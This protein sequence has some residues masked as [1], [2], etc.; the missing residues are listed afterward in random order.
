M[1]TVVL[2]LRMLLAAIFVTAAVG[3]LRDLPGSRRAVQDFGVPERAARA[4]AL[5]LPLAELAVAI[6]LIPQPSARWGALGAV[7]LLALF[8]AGIA[9]ALSRGEQP[10][11]HCF[12]QI[13]SAPAGRGTLVRNGVLA[14]LAVV[15][16]MYGNGPAIDDWISARGAAELAAV[17]LGICAIVAAAYAWTLRTENKTLSADLRIARKAGAIGGRFGLPVG[18][19][20]PSFVLEDMRREPVTLA[21]LRERG[22]PVLLLFVSPGCGPC[23]TMVPRV[24]QWQETLSERLTVAVVS[25]GTPEQNA[26][27]AEGGLEDVLLQDELEVAAAFHVQG[28]PTAVVVSR[29][30]RIASNL[31][32]M[33]QAIEPLVRLA[34]RQGVDV[35][36]VEGSVS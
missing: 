21:N 15:I 26:A 22:R 10:D 30:G 16:V 5:M 31:G 17:A 1:G 19:E 18:T 12:G 35:A 23:G 14:A 8:I 6:A 4:V 32:V 34:L 11:C 25:T 13:H 24:R 7:I 33:E 2:A 9:R 28:T 29:D 36:S 20:A 3:K 27:L